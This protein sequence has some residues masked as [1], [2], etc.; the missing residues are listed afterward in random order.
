MNQKVNFLKFFFESG[1]FSEDRTVTEQIIDLFPAIVCIYDV[2]SGEIPFFNRKFQELRQHSPVGELSGC[3]HEDEKEGFEEF[4]HEALNASSY[5]ERTFRLASGTSAKVVM[6]SVKAEGQLAPSLL[7][8]AYESDAKST[9]TLIPTNTILNQT[10]ELLKFGSWTWCPSTGEVAWSPG[11]FRLLGYGDDVAASLDFFIEHVVPED[12]PR[13]RAIMECPDDHS[14]FELAFDIRTRDKQI[15]TLC[16]KGRM[17][18][19]APGGVKKFVGIISDITEQKEFERQQNQALTDLNRSNRELEEFA[20]VASHDLQEPLR[21]IAMFTERLQ[22]R[23]SRIFD[24]DANVVL[25]RILAST[26]NMKHL[27]D[28]LLDFSRTAHRER[29]YSQVDLGQVMQEVISNFEIKIAESNASIEIGALPTIHAITVEMQQLFGNLISNA[30][31]FRS[32]E[33]TPTIRVNSRIASREE[34]E[35]LHLATELRYHAITVAD[36]GIGFDTQYA[37]KI[38]EIFQRLNSKTQYPGS[39]I[40]LAICRKIVDNHRGVILP[41]SRPGEGSTF[42]IFLPE[43]L[44]H[45]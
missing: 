23:Y 36:N 27:I 33:K 44:Y 21:K 34:L 5:I 35:R 13:V 7:F 14:Q 32:P 4:C 10:E 19:V 15:K 25:E 3:V 31:K 40:G 18:P 1:K 45:E 17:V 38:F 2:G 39:G 30:L 43:T 6:S 9:V 24:R 41:D 8:I 11:I 26:D 20:Y 37:D 16:S 29:T 12:K 22:S 28:N 42:T